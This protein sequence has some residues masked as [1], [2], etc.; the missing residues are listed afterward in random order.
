MIDRVIVIVLDSVGIGDAPDADA[1]G[2]AGSNTLANI[3]KAVGGLH[4]PNLQK[5]GLGNIGPIK[6]IPPEPA[7]S[8]ES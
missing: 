3:A 4:L 6:G 8:R 1:F 5:M 7:P 2:D